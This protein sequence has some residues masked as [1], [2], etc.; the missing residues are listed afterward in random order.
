MAKAAKAKILEL[1]LPFMKSRRDKLAKLEEQ[2]KVAAEEEYKKKVEENEGNAEGVEQVQPKSVAL[3]D[4][5]PDL[6][7]MFK[8]YPMSKEEALELGKQGYAVNGI[9]VVTEASE[10]GWASKVQEGE[11]AP[12]ED[13]LI[14][15]T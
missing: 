9:M 10:F 11:E 7:I 12:S 1:S 15:S 5:D 3:D 6:F 2:A 14:P 4:T 13:D 8:G